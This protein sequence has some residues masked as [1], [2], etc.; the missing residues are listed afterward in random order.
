MN[1]LN[2]I[3]I[4]LMGGYSKRMKKDK[5][6]LYYKNKFW[7]EI[8]YNELKKFFDNV[9]LS[10]RKEQFIQYSRELEKFKDFIITDWKFSIEGPLKGMLSTYAYFLNIKNLKPNFFLSQQI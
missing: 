6:F 1:T 9:Y 5:A 8:I 4:I 3:P 2:L 10:L 7:F